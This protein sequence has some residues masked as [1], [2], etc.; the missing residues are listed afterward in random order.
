MEEQQKKRR[1]FPGWAKIVIAVV[2]TLVLT[3]GA[4]AGAAV[5]VFGKDGIA[6]MQGYL[7]A[8]FSFVETDAD[9]S[10]AVDS[11]LNGMVEGLGDRWSYYLDPESYQNTLQSRANNY[12]GIGV[13]VSYDREDGLL[14]QEVTEEG[15]AQQAGV[16]AG[17]VITHVDGTSVAGDARYEATDRIA[18]EEGTQVELT[19]LREDGTT[20]TVTCTRQ[21]LK[22][23]SV[24]SKLLDNGVGYVRLDNF[25][26]GAASSLS[27]EVQSLMD[28][29]ATSLV[30]DVRSNPGGYVAELIAALDY[31]LPEGPIF[32]E[33]PRWGKETVYE[34]D[35]SCVDLPMVVMVDANS[36]S[37][38]ELFAAQLRES[39]QA[40]IVG[41][42][43][44]GKG[45]AQLT[46]PLVN[47]G[48]LGLSVSAYC[49][50]GGH[51]LIGEGIQPDVELSLDDS[52]T[53]NQ[54]QA[55]IDLLLK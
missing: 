51:S 52:G 1:R 30:L 13:T 47:G 46:F 20:R 18:G 24:S 54:L 37:A 23:D 53:D 8:K 34:S 7:L 27:R 43:T 55:A 40:P 17:D 42:V 9:L 39:V 12:V 28:Q 11:A 5:V 32:T 22:S 31:L 2:L 44:S 25:Y 3:L 21:T 45:Y 10:K 16:K 41:E 19:L 4:V 48:G 36:Y 15:P 14:V 33:R 29:G 26:S 49:T 50:G 6:L 38:A 35:A